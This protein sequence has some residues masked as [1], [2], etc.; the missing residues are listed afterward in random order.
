MVKVL[1]VIEGKIPKLKMHDFESQ[2]VS[3]R[4]QPK[5]K[6]M[7]SSTLLRDDSQ[8]GTYRVETLWQSREA[9][10][11]TQKSK[12]TT[13]AIALFKSHGV[14]P[15]IRIFEVSMIINVPQPGG[16]QRSNQ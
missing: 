12:Q 11:E 15:A 13:L 8:D 5:P 14:E 16:F 1:M 4:D 2:Y 9:M 6:G 3:I 7:I 10:E